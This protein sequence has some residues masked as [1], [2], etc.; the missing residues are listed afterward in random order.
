MT[1]SST[2]LIFWLEVPRKYF[3]FS[4]K[5]HF[6]SDLELTGLEWIVVWRDR[7][8]GTELIIYRVSSQ[9]YASK[10]RMV[11][12]SKTDVISFEG[13]NGRK[14]VY[15]AFILFLSQLIIP[16]RG[17]NRNGRF[18]KK[19]SG[20]ENPPPPSPSPL[21]RLL[22]YFWLTGLTKPIF[23]FWSTV[24]HAT[25]LLR[26]RKADFWYFIMP[27]CIYSV[28]EGMKEWIWKNAYLRHFGIPE[29]VNRG[30]RISW[31]GLQQKLTRR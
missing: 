29:S 26:L 13:R 1:K 12:A 24:S 28:T 15:I 6:I 25:D 18:G 16:K 19:R 8:I 7:Q 21:H 22:N 3:H 17:T 10:C 20:K 2:E 5:L 30:T 27:L 14:I 9:V 31:S 23:F 11:H 4:R